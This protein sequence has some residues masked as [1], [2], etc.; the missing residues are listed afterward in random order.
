MN[1]IKTLH[2]HLKTKTCWC[3]S[4]FLTLLKPPACL[5]PRPHSSSCHVLLPGKIPKIFIVS[6]SEWIYAA[7]LNKSLQT[8]WMKGGRQSTRWLSRKFF[9]PAQ[10]SIDKLFIQYLIKQSNNGMY[11]TEDNELTSPMVYCHSITFPKPEMNVELHIF[12]FVIWSNIMS[13]RYIFAGTL[14]NCCWK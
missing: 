10:S 8:E 6:L 2:I 9:G 3:P 12:R 13:Q 1:I 5:Q 14:C 4:K 11:F 7:S